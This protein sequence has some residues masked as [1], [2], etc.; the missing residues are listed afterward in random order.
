[1]AVGLHK[2]TVQESVN[3]SLGQGGCQF[4]NT[5][6]TITPVSGDFIAI[7]FIEDTLLDLLTPVNGA[8][9]AGDS[10]GA[11]DDIPASLTFPAGLTIF[12]R[13]SAFSISGSASVLAYLG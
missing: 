9:Y 10:S 1:M 4:V 2:H 8:I 12:G 7:T 5:A 6:G 11:G 13:W 3:A